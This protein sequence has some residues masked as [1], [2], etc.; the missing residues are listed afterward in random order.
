METLH[1]I[2]NFTSNLQC[3]RRASA[4]GCVDLF[5]PPTIPTRAGPR[6]WFSAHDRL[7]Y[8]SVLPVFSLLAGQG[9]S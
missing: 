6:C 1:I 9:S 4:I 2:W 8:L 7:F 5:P 3:I